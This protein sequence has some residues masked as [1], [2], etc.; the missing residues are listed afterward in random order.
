MNGIKFDG[1]ISGCGSLIEY[2]GEVLFYRT[3]P[4]DLAAVALD[5][6]KKN[7]VLPILEGKD[8]IYFDEDD[9]GIAPYRP[10]L[11]AA[12]GDRLLPLKSNFGK[13]EFSK[14][15][16]ITA[17]NISDVAACVAVLEKFFDFQVHDA[18]YFEMTAKGVNKGSAI[19]IVCEKLQIDVA[20]TIA[21]GDSMNDL[22]MLKAAGTA[23]AMANAPSEVKAV[24]D[25][26]TDLAEDDGIANALRHFNLTN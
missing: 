4:T 21:V 8:F 10:D 25:Y 1:V 23:I 13:W 20:D 17:P 14:F 22:D 9:F 26:V 18:N 15:S 24:A 5:V 16:G 19:K 7:K 11:K 3:I 2:R 12:L 6:F